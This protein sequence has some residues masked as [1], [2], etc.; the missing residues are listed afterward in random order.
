MVP[1]PVGYDVSPLPLLDHLYHAGLRVS[2]H[3]QEAQI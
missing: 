2:A 1:I 3:G